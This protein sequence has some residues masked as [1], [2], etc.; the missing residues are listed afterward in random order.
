MAVVEASVWQWS[1]G[2]QWAKLREW[3]TFDFLTA[4]ETSAEQF[5]SGWGGPQ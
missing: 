2:S 3:R 1:L 5:R 4:K